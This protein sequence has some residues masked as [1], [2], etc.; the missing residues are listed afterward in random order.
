MKFRKYL[1]E[2][3][4]LDQLKNLLKTEYN[5]AY[6]SGVVLYRGSR[7]SID[8]FSIFNKSKFNDEK[9]LERGTGKPFTIDQLKQI[10]P[11]WNKFNDRNK[12]IFFTSNINH[13]QE[14]GDYTYRIF[15]CNKSKISTGVADFNYFRKWEFL[16]HTFGEYFNSSYIR[17][18]HFCIELI[19]NYKKIEKIKEPT[20]LDLLPNPPYEIAHSIFE[21]IEYYQKLID[22]QK[23]LYPDLFHRYKQLIKKYYS[24]DNTYLDL[25]NL[26]VLKVFVKQYNCD[27][28]KM[29]RDIFDPLKNG[30][31][32]F[33]V[34]HLPKYKNNME[35][36]TDENCLIVD[37]WKL[38]KI[39][40]EI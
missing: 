10:A 2:E 35:F 32:V 11:E 12:S 20:T 34:I 33:N 21:K 39:K 16:E 24:Y 19:I 17:D 25:I 37:E 27:L 36:W 38:R 31:E 3:E 26:G 22:E 15:P 8:V 1:V 4:K 6:R 9:R 7:T 18:F 28:L 40:N 23:K 30:F 29:F 5:E 14:F 13:S